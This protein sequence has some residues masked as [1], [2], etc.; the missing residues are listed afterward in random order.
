MYGTR[1]DTKE[2]KPWSKW[3][4]KDDAVEGL[5]DTEDLDAFLASGRWMFENAMEGGEMTDMEFILDSGK[6]IRGHKVWLMARC[7]YIRMMMSSGMREARTGIVHVKECSDG[8]FMALLEYIYTGELGKSCLG[9]DWGELWNVAH[10][11]GMPK[12][13]KCLLAAVGMA[14]V[15]EAAAV[16]AERGIMDLI[17]ECVSQL[18]NRTRDTSSKKSD[19]R[20]MIRTMDL[21]VQS[22]EA[23]RWTSDLVDEGIQVIRMAMIWEEI[24]DDAFMTERACATL[25]AMISMD[26]VYGFDEADVS[27]IVE[28]AVKK[29]KTNEA[30]QGHAWTA[31]EYCGTHR[32]LYAMQDAMRDS[33]EW[34]QQQCCRSLQRHL[35]VCRP[36]KLQ[37]GSDGEEPNLKEIVCTAVEAS[38]S[39]RTTDWEKT[40]EKIA[41]NTSMYSDPVDDMLQNFG[42]KALVTAMSAYQTE[43]WVQERCCHYL[44]MLLEADM[45]QDTRNINV[46]A[47]NIHLAWNDGGFEA[48]LNAMKSN[49]GS[50]IVQQNGCRA[51]Q[52]MQ[53]SGREALLNRGSDLDVAADFAAKNDQ[54]YGAI[55]DAVGE[56]ADSTKIAGY[57]VRKEALE[58]LPLM[59]CQDTAERRTKIA[60]V[61]LNAIETTVREDMHFLACR[62]IQLVCRETVDDEVRRF[63]VEADGVQ[64]IVGVLVECNRYSDW[65]AEEDTQDECCGALAKLCVDRTVQ[66]LAGSCGAV[67]AVVDV[68][69]KNDY[70]N[71]DSPTWES[72]PLALTRLCANHQGNHSLA[73]QRARIVGGGIADY[74]C[75]GFED[76]VDGPDSCADYETDEYDTDCRLPDG[77]YRRYIP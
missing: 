54:M 7:E 20:T 31:L 55:M 16:G 53:T 21:L 46:N 29:H 44:A 2:T 47:V 25:E 36:P 52:L 6:R 4:L 27:E 70:F 68:I 37:V 28:V 73:W 75:E 13:G 38:R 72:A 56:Y 17:E 74:V 24:Q 23:T 62:A 33:D 40:W 1:A 12:M 77:R 11:F 50:A 67:Q 58:A 49:K 65:S 5:R 18:E 71:S 32:L 26:G 34:M 59:F 76:W 42:V 63:V 61:A 19:A 64:A 48:V 3:I 22:H 30:V 10:L 41:E 60:T 8:A 66:D 39:E 35:S 45:V 51:L 14:N 57:L 43:S 9:Q 69:V 15:E